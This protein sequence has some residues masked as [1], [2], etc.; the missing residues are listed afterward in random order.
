M[1]LPRVGTLPVL[2]FLIRPSISSHTVE[3]AAC[4]TLAK[5]LHALHTALCAQIVE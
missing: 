3:L 1:K 4:K 2:S 5:A